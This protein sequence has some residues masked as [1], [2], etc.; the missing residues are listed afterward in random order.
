MKINPFLLI[1]LVILLSFMFTLN[2]QIFSKEIDALNVVLT[3]FNISFDLAESLAVIKNFH[4]PS[5]GKK[6]QTI[7]AQGQGIRAEIELIKP[8]SQLKAKE[9]SE[10]KYIII[11]SLFEPHVIP[12]KGELTHTSGCLDKY[13]PIEV[14]AEV[15]GK[16]EKALILNAT[17][18][19][20][21]GVCDDKMIKY[22][23]VFVAFYDEVNKIHYQLTIFQPS[24]LFDQEYVLSILKSLKRF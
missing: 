3:R 5:Q 22:K 9:Y 11:E 15:L 12:Y 20:V 10:S 17:D 2:Q 19:Y 4:Y 7:V 1:L 18:R 24:D 21:L 23:A 16:S 6:Y 8:I 13:K 14:T